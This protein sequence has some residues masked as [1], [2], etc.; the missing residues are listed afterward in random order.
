M[1]AETDAEIDA[2]VFECPLQAPSTGTTCPA[3][4][5]ATLCAYLGPDPGPIV[6]WVC[7]GGGWVN[8]TPKTPPLSCVDINCTPGSTAECIAGGT[9]CCVCDSSTGTTRQCG[10]CN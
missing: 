2:H 4:L 9:E 1:D 3:A 8:C 10:P 6:E 7:V 5:S